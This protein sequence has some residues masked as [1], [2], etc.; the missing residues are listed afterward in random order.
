MSEMAF[1]ADMAIFSLKEML[2]KLSLIE[3]VQLRQL[4]LEHALCCRLLPLR[5]LLL[6]DLLRGDRKDLSLNGRCWTRHDH[7]GSSAC[8][9]RCDPDGD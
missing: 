3:V 4:L 9:G 2:A 8:I 1:A 5:R 6:N 7:R